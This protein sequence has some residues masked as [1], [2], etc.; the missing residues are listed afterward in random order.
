MTNHPFGRGGH[1]E[2]WGNKRAGES[3]ELLV[4][5]EA[6]LAREIEEAEA[7]GIGFV[8]LA[9]GGKTHLGTGLSSKGL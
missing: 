7:R 8:R 3:E 9:P 1:S 4:Y 5:G 6:E 2:C